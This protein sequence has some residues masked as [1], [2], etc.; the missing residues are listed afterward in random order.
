V[1]L[2]AVWRLAANKALALYA[3]GVKNMLGTF[4]TR[5][6]VACLY[7]H[8]PHVSPSSSHTT[9]THVYMCARVSPSGTHAVTTHMYLPPAGARPDE[10]HQPS[11][12]AATPH[13]DQGPLIG[14]VPA[15]Q[16]HTPLQ[17]Q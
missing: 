3:G 14:G 9:V 5:S 10:P 4:S 2:H 16:R 6:T 15:V 7:S 17:W 12:A 11:D 8:R 1:L 13:H